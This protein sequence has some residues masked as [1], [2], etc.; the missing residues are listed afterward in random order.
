M[1]KTGVLLVFL[2]DVLNEWA[3]RHALTRFVH[4]HHDHAKGSAVAH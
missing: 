1:S 4:H 3:E 2:R